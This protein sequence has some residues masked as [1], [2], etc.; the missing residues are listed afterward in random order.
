M[1]HP[2]LSLTW[3]NNKMF[4]S[5]RLNQLQLPVGIIDSAEAQVNR[6]LNEWVCTD[7]NQCWS[8]P[9]PIQNVNN[10]L[11]KKLAKVGHVGIKGG[12]SLVNHLV[13]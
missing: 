12:S 5:L 11:N 13:H 2:G 1:I 8:N 6:N 3:D 4:T 10:T 7:M 9:E